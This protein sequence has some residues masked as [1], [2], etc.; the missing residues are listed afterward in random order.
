MPEPERTTVSGPVLLFWLGVFCFVPVALSALYLR[1]IFGMPAWIV[2]LAAVAL[3]WLT[4]AVMTIVQKRRGPYLLL[5]V[6]ACGW[7]VVITMV[8]FLAAG[9]FNRYGDRGGPPGTQRH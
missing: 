9:E 7:F 4:T 2:V 8:L 1:H 3:A 5:P 6:L